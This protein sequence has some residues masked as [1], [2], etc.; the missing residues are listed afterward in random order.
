[1]TAIT[2]YYQARAREYEAIYD[3]PERQ[4]DLA[5]LRAWLLAETTG[6]R[7]LE[8]ACGTG[9]WTAV[10]APSAASILGTDYNDG[11]LS[12]ARAKGLGPHVT[13]ARAD[14]YALA[15]DL[16]AFD[17][18]MAH[19]WWSHVPKSR[20]QAFLGHLASRLQ[21]GARLLMIDNTYVPGSST[22]ISR[23]DTD[24]NSWQQR[25]LAS[26]ARHEVLKNFPTPGELQAVFARVSGRVEVRQLTY[27][28]AL[29]ATLV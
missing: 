15:P 11:P 5:A 27:Y 17:C 21:P 16:G 14:A 4:A 28:W 3:K 10:A 12:I 23:T 29:T 7:V 8:V 13:F 25:M 24:G 6:C 20:Q 1:M 22:P 26:G 2:D 18:G 9:W 19:F